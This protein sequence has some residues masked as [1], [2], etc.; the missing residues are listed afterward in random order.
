M[1]DN[2]LN[3]SQSSTTVENV[4]KLITDELGK[5][6]SDKLSK[7]ENKDVQAVVDIISNDI[8]KLS[9]KP[10]DTSVVR[11]LAIISDK[12]IDDDCKWRFQ[13]T[14][15]CRVHEYNR[16]LMCNRTPNQFETKE[17][18][19]LWINISD[20]NARQWVQKNYNELKTDWTL[21]TVYGKWG[22]WVSEIQPNNIMSLKQFKDNFQF[23]DAEELSHIITN[24]TH[25]KLKPKT[26]SI[27]GCCRSLK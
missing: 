20:K 24:V 3:S 23:L 12:V 19:V 27:L 26:F 15:G 2:Q 14:S 10:F 17:I 4:T 7:S 21:I 13:K 1:S 9:D 11:N 8:R 18:D 5:I 16:D 6:V 22:N 25:L